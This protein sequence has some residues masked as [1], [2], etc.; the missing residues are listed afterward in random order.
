[1]IARGDIVTYR[2]PGSKRVRIQKAEL[3]ATLQ[4]VQKGGHED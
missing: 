4:R 3:L 1:M 2:L